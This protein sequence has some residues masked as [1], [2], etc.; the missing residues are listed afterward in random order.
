MHLLATQAGTIDDGTQAVDLQQNPGDIV[1]LSAADTELSCLAQA[2]STLP[3]DFPIVR[4][5]I[6]CGSSIRCP[7]ISMS[8][9]SSR[10]PSWW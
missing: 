4:L 9:R 2:R 10:T 1:V 5:R 3:A 6:S 7:S 8:R